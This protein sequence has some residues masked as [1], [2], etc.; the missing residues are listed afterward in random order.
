MSKT[1]AAPTHWWVIRSHIDRFVVRLCL[2]VTAATLIAAATVYMKL[3]DDCTNATHWRLEPFGY[4]L[5]L[6]V[7][8]SPASCEKIPIATH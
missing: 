5:E 1:N 4:V 7:S 3:R 6:G 2:L 8:K